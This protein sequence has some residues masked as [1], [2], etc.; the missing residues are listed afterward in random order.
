MDKNKALEALETRINALSRVV[1][2][3]ADKAGGEHVMLGVFV[4]WLE[5]KNNLSPN[6]FEA[7][8]TSSDASGPS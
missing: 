7:L 4:E 2:E 8:R 3:L 6:V 1:S 5:I